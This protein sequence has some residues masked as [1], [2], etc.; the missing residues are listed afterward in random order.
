MKKSEFKKLFG[1]IRKIMCMWDIDIDY[2]RSENMNDWSAERMYQYKYIMVNFNPLIL[3]TE[4]EDIVD[5]IIH[6]LSHYYLWFREPFVDSLVEDHWWTKKE[7]DIAWN[8]IL[9]LEEQSAVSITRIVKRLFLEKK[10][11]EKTK[12]LKKTQKNHS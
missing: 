1:E 4:Y 2:T 9:D 7:R 10:Q 12:K 8:W 6:E 11:K 5:T 3:A